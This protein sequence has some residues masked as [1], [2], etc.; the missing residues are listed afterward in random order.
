MQIALFFLL[1]IL[2]LFIA[3][4]DFRSRKIS[5]IVLLLWL[6]SALGSVLLKHS[7]KEVFF[8]AALNCLFVLIVFFIL[9]VYSSA[10]EKKIINIIDTKIGMGDFIFFLVLGISFSPSNYILFFAASSFL[11]L[12]WAISARLLYPKSS[13]EIPLAGA[14]AVQ[15]IFLLSLRIFISGFDLYGDAWIINFLFNNF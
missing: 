8:N 1:G 5:L 4:E 15:F 6:L 13:K 10:K 14:L 12:I 2:S 9:T 3:V 7:L 11:T